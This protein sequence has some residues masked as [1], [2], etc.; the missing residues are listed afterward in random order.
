V[1]FFKSIIHSVASLTY[2]EAQ[3]MIDD[4]NLQ[5]IRYSMHVD[6]AINCTQTRYMLVLLYS[7]V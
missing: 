4:P 2:N 7:A 6:T 1:E 3:I 5:D